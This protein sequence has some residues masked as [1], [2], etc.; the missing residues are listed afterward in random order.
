MASSATEGMERMT[1]INTEK[2]AVCPLCGSDKLI[3]FLE[4]ADYETFTGVYHIEE[5]Q[6]CH[7]KFTNPRPTAS[8]LPK[9]YEDRNSSD[10]VKPFILIDKLRSFSIRR[11]LA[12]LPNEMLSGNKSVLDFGC[13]DGFFSKELADF[14]SGLGVVAT[15]FHSECPPRIVDNPQVKYRSQSLFQE[16]NGQYD[17][18]FCRHVLEHA[19]DPAAFIQALEQ[20]LTKNGYL[21]I[22]VPNADSIWAKVFRNYYFAY[23]LPRHLFHFNEATLAPLLRSFGGK[24]IAKR[25]TP[26]LGRS[27]GYMM[28]LPIENT[29]ILGLS[30]YPLQL[31][32]DKLARSSTTLLAIAQKS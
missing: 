19:L 30:L 7:I 12:E 1:Q 21:V 20:R 29:G 23:Y 22:E 24:T 32:L 6:G 14:N 10:F 11:S 4:G 16:E 3:I 13:G 8:D 15:D 2:L 18:I 28:R 9:L 5:C 25:N 17:V 26:V 27:L 31:I